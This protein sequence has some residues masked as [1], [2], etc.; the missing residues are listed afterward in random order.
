MGQRP[1]ESRMGP[2]QLDVYDASIEM[3][4]SG[5]LGHAKANVL[6]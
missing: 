1:M 2:G 6:E 3:I 4:T 5:S